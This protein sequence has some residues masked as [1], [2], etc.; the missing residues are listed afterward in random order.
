MKIDIE[1]LPDSPDSLKEI[2]SHL[3]KQLGDYCD[4]GISRAEYCDPIL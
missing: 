2:I 1:N 3:T 4:T